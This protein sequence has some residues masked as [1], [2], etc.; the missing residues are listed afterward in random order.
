MKKKPLISIVITYYKKKDFIKKTLES[1]L[2][3][4]YKNYEVIF[5]YDQEEKKDLKLI[6]KLLSKFKNMKLIVNKK[7]F[8]VSKS[9]NIAI[10]HVKGKYLAF[11]DSDDLWKKNKLMTQFNFMKKN[12]YLFSFTSYA[13]IDE[14]NKVI[15]ERKVLF[16]PYYNNLYRSNFIGLS[17][18]MVNE[19]IFSKIYFPNLKTQ[20]DLALWLK[21]LR[22][23]IKIKCLNKTLSF[24][25]KT[26]NSLSSNLY[27]KLIDAFKLYYFYEKKNFIISIFSVI[28]LSCNKILKKF[29]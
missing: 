19:K 22:Q 18:V 2:N 11:I 4:T 17:T 26:K 21:L 1:I 29:N 5:V 13:E 6:K 8:G 16:D 25:R 10:K 12:H 20:E 7:N 3:Q 14:K 28:I 24:W 23:G 9:R 15:R 27:R